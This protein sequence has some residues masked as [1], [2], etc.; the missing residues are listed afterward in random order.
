MNRLLLILFIVI[1]S[2]SFSQAQTRSTQG[3]VRNVDPIVRFFPNP[4]TTLVTFDF[5][6][7]YERGYSIQVYSFLGK[8]VFESKNMSQR[9]IINLTD[10][11]RGVYVYQLRDRSGRM[12]E[13]GKFQVSR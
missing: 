4:A 2:F 1:S 6:K 11:N 13:S 5:Q 12:V 3:T 8:K 9:T 7:A 10:Y